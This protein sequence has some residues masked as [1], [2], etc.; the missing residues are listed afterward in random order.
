MSFT[1]ECN[2]MTFNNIAIPEVEVQKDLGLL[3]SRIMK[4]NETISNNIS[5]ALK[6]FYMLKRNTPKGLPMR[7]KLNIFKSMILQV[8]LY[9]SSCW[10][11]SIKMLRLIEKVQEKALTWVNGRNDYVTNLMQCNILPLTLY[12]QL[13]DLLFMSKMLNGYYKI[14]ATEYF[15]LKEFDRATRLSEK[16]F[17]ELPKIKKSIYQQ[18]FWLR[19]CKLVN[20]L[21]N[22]IDFSNHQGL[23]PRLLKHFWN[24]FMTN[25]RYNDIS[26]WKLAWRWNLRVETPKL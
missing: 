24:Y 21:P 14:D 1:G 22:S 17:F 20:I 9:G 3:V 8:L 26:T 16:H 25:Y 5:K 6:T 19:T 15:C 4:W 12:M 13:L 2:Q 23:K 18:E 7:V 10:A 11:A